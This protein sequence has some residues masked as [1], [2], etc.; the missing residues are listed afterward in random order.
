[1]AGMLIEME[2]GNHIG[3][4]AAEFYDCSA[5]RLDPLSNGSFN[6]VD[7]EVVEAGQIQSEV[8]PS[9]LNIFS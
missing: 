5:F 9:I 6:D 3:Y 8:L 2:K 7:G 1:M 4:K